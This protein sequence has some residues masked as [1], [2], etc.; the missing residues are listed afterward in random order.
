MSA[1]NSMDINTDIEIFEH[2]WWTNL[3]GHLIFLA[4]SIALVYVWYYSRDY[5]AEINRWK[6]QVLLVPPL[7]Y[8][9]FRFPNLFY[10]WAVPRRIYFKQNK[11]IV[12]GPLAQT[13]QF[14]YQDITHFKIRR[15]PGWTE[16]WKWIHTSFRA[17]IY[18]SNHSFKVRFN[19]DGLV[20]FH[21]VLELIR[22]KGLGQVIQNL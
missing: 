6:L 2:P 16:P 20:E 15:Q 9:L 7:I 18:F 5:V 21:S 13:H 8:F 3:L 11:I 10:L 14:S 17:T 1:S 19:P 4:L 12:V 22:A